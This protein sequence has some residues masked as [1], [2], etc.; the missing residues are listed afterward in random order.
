[1]DVPHPLKQLQ[2]VVLTEPFIQGA[3]DLDEVAEVASWKV[4]LGK[5]G[6]FLGDLLAYALISS[7]IGLRHVLNVIK[8]VIVAQ[9]HLRFALR[10]NEFVESDLIPTLIQQN[11]LQRVEL[12]ILERSVA[13]AQL[14]CGVDLCKLVIADELLKFVVAKG[15]HPFQKLKWITI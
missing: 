2:E 11:D 15:F 3:M 12:P 13:L 8:Y 9:V 10:L 6:S 5:E 7:Q 14:R 4:L 1:M